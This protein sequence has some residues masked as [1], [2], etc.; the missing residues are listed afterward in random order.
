MGEMMEGD[1]GMPGLHVL[2]LE[3]DSADAATLRHALLGT[4]PGVR[5][6]VVGRLGAALE[7]LHDH[8]VGCVVTNLR[9]PDA[10]GV[11]IVQALRAAC[12]RVPVIVIAG[13]ASAELA[14]AAMKTG[15]ADYVRKHARLAAQLPALV[16]EVLGRSILGAV[17]DAH[18]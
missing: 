12:R 5:V 13:D 9:L 3:D 11:R 16:R 7:A 15:A 18:P 14:V 17:D 10:E 6:T 2:L 8:R 4:E 1:G